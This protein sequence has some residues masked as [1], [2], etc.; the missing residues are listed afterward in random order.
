M[1]ERVVIAGL[2]MF[3]AFTSCVKIEEDYNT[4][5]AFHSVQLKHS[6]IQG[7]D[8]FVIGDYKVLAKRKVKELQVLEC[9]GTSCQ[10]SYY[11][12]DKYGNMIYAAPSYNMSYTK[13]EYDKYHNLQKELVSYDGKKIEA[14]R[15]Y[16]Y[17]KDS[18]VV[19]LKDDLGRLLYQDEVPNPSYIHDVEYSD[20]KR[21]SAQIIYNM[22]FPC[23]EEYL[24]ENRITFQYL[25]GGLISSVTIANVATNQQKSFDFEY[26]F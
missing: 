4:E 3:I 18:V 2:I 26:K 10:G 15:N 9:N 21:V 19:K 12:F 1:L 24:D 6:L 16:N 14:T 13:F 17:F 11:K 25:K 20:S 8:G 7:I 22:M 23:G 5:G